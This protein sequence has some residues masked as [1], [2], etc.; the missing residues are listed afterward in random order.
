MI[1]NLEKISPFSWR[2]KKT[3]PMN[4][5]VIIFASE[6]LLEN[7]KKDKSIDQLIDA[8]CLPDVISP[9]LGMPDIHQGFGLP[10]GG[11]MATRGLISAGGVG[12]DI[13]CGVRLLLSNLEYDPKILT[14]EVL[15][16]L[17]ERI[18]Q[19]I[20]L[21]IGGRQKANNLDLSLKKVAEEGVNFLVKKGLATPED[22]E[23]IEENGRMEGASF[24]ALTKKAIKRAQNQLGTL[25]S[26]NHFI[27]IQRVTKIFDLQIAQQ[28]NLHENQICVMLHT[29]SRA[30]GHQTCLDYTEILWQAKNYYGINIPNKGLAALPVSTNE[31]KNYFAAMAA[32]VNFAFANRQVI[33]HFIRQAWQEIFGSQA[34][35]ELLYDIA[36]NIAKWE[37]F[38]SAQDKVLIHRKGA[39]RALPPGHPQNPQKFINSGHPALI[40]GSMGTASYVIVGTAKNKETFHSVNH[41]AGR[42]MSRRQAF[43]QISQK[44]FKESM[45][46]VLYNLPYYKLADEAPSAYKDIE[47]VVNILAKAGIAKK[48][49]QPKPLAVAKGA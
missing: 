13:N 21:G 39:T 3:P 17:I 5:E 43:R 23:S 49:A 14:T 40:P 36:H 22:L 38:D 20:P 11:V 12:M 32:C 47:E 24:E 2:I 28:F 1:L 41:G 9:V 25:G 16:E 42:I 45:K 15:R 29:G 46:G 37:S 44:E 26:G 10:I 33:T 27:E 19:F 35:L 30:L 4:A 7:I 34:E 8:A 18:S 48:V 31:G 6:K